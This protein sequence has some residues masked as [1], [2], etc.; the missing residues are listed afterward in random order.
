[1]K[2]KASKNRHSRSTT[3]VSFYLENE[4]LNAVQK[5]EFAPAGH[6]ALEPA[7]LTQRLKLLI[8]EALKA[9][10]IETRVKKVR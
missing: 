4:L 7:N 9:R 1:M 2:Q 10:G 6:E 8:K 5:I 3:G